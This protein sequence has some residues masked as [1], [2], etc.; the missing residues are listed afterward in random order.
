MKSKGAAIREIYRDHKQN[1]INVM[2][3]IIHK[4]TNLAIKKASVY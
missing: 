4:K 3:V 2:M 1:F